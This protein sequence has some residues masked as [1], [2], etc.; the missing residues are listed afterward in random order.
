MKK[1]KNKVP[2]ETRFL[3]ESKI[4]PKRQGVEDIQ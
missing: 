2:L 3:S 4:K 1:E